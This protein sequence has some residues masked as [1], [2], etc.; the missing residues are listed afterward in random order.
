M[1]III[2]QSIKATIINYIGAFIGF[3]TTIFVLTKFLKPD[4]IGLTKVMYEVAALIAGFAQLGT[5]ASAMRFFPYFKNPAKKHNGFFFYLMMMPTIG[6]IVFISLFLL[7][8]GLIVNFF[9]SKSSLLVSYYDWIVP[10]ILFLVFW[11]VFETYANVL[12]RIVIPK[13]IREVVIRLLLLAVYLMYAFHLIDLNGM[14]IGFVLSYG[15]TMISCF[16][17]LSQITSISLNHDFTYIDKELSSKIIKYTLFLILG[18]LSGSII[19]QLDLF[20]ISS[21]MGLE[22]AGIYTIAMY[23]AAVIEMPARSITAISAPIAA[24]SLKEGNLNEANQLYKKVALHQFMA[25]STLFLFIWINIDN[26]FT[27]VPNGEIYQ[28]GKWVVFFL[29]MSRLISLTLSFGG[30]LIS[31]S[32]YYFWGLYFTCFL[33][34]LTIVSNSLLIPVFGMTGAA[35]ATVIT[36]FISY[37]IQQWI[38]VRKIKGNPYSSGIMKQ[39][40]VILLL[41]SI[42]ELL[43]LHIIN[44]YFDIICRSAPIA[45]LW[46]ILTYY[47]RISGEFKN[48]IDKH[49]FRFIKNK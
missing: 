17:Y 38:V 49:V 30:I 44:P 14:V 39:I 23:M 11:A 20:M 8:K 21:K 47:L 12:L 42:N 16:F 5:S 18:A 32:R 1:G 35:I 27:I 7:L 26:I 43:P 41:V 15:V 10:L 25:G 31:F 36:C 6:C 45:L 2:R 22:Y 9:E 13:F 28:S 46:F 40:G 33:T 4:E 29:A 19:G 3:I 37:S 24:F 48:L 34:F